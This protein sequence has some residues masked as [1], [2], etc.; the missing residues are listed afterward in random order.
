[1]SKGR[2]FLPR[3]HMDMEAIVPRYRGPE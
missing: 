1:L 2:L 3:G